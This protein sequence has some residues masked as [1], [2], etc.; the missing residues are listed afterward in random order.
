MMRANSWLYQFYSLHSKMHYGLAYEAHTSRIPTYYPTATPTVMSHAYHGSAGCGPEASV[1]SLHPVSYHHIHSSIPTLN[2]AATAHPHHTHHP[3]AVPIAPLHPVP[4]HHI[5]SAVAPINA[6]PGH[7]YSQSVPQYSPQSG[8][9]PYPSLVAAVNAS[10][11][12]AETEMSKHASSEKRPNSPQVV[13]HASEDAESPGP[14]SK[15]PNTHG[16]GHHNNLSLKGKNLY[17]PLKLDTYC[18]IIKSFQTQWRD[19]A[20]FDIV[21]F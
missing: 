20:D 19:I 13:H 3:Q 12:S 14:P 21:T 16:I 2:A 18:P 9:L 4:Y 5:H 11:Q 8:S 7:H 17:P 10:A 6:S 1:P 15:R